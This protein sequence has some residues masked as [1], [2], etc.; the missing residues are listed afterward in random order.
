LASFVLSSFIII[1]QTGIYSY[2]RFCILAY[3]TKG[4]LI[5]CN[6]QEMYDFFY[7]SEGLLGSGFAGVVSFIGPC[8]VRFASVLNSVSG[9][10]KFWDGRVR[11]TVEIS[12]SFTS[13]SLFAFRILPVY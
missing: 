2:G 12:L 11:V 1:V 8:G 7:G 9:E 5:Y 6:S 10:I 13:Y 3:G 4:G